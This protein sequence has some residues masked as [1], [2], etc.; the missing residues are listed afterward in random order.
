MKPV[1]RPIPS[2]ESNLFKTA[3]YKNEKEFEHP[4]HFHSEYEL[5]YI[6]GSHGVRY[7]GNS[8]ENFWEDDLV[9]V[10]SNL[11]HRWMNVPDQQRPPSS[12]VVYL[13]EEFRD[14]TWMQ[15]CE[16]DS[17]RRLLDL[18]NR[19]IKFG[20]D[21]ALKLKERCFELLDLS[22]M[23]K[24]MALLD[25]LQELTRANEYHFLCELGY[26]N[27][28]SDTNNERI[29]KAYRYIEAHYQE[30]IFLADIAA[31][32][33]MSS[34]YFSRFFKKIMK[35][36]FVEFLNEY[37]INNACKL[38]IETDKQISEICYA[39]GFESIPF[40]YRQF[41]KIKNC[42]PSHYRL[43]YQRARLK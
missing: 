31:H 19:G 9:L 15:S 35:I 12:L 22:S 26:A 20:K 32:L 39:S 7:V 21:V 5:T 18:S 38:L 11:P 10:G 37:K 33:H 36:S 17:I 24:L 16:F 14:K 41:K 6:L 29:S 30:K 1:Y 43:N 34:E 28:L 8:I 27:E 23:D 4:W 13:N 2:N 40:F 25:I 42:Q 3:I